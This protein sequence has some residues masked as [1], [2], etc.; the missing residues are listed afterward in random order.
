[1]KRD[2]EG[3]GM[4]DDLDQPKGEQCDGCGEFYPQVKLT[5][6]GTQYCQ[7]ADCQRIRFDDERAYSDYLGM[8]ENGI[9]MEALT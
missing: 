6:H 2:A 9:P 1:M 4:D 3:Y 7:R 8:S 5:G